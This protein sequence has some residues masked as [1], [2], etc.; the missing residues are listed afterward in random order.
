MLDHCE[1]YPCPLRDPLP[2]IRVPLRHGEREVVLD[3][4]P[5]ID[6][7]YKIGRYHLLLPYEETPGALTAEDQNWAKEVLDEAE[8][9]K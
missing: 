8:Y 5:L 9:S 1:V 4:Q 6:R 7:C 3:L 2:A